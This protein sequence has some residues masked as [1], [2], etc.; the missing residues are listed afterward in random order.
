[1]DSTTL[2]IIIGASVGGLIIIG[3]ILYCI[4]RRKKTASAPEKKEEVIEVQ[5]VQPKTD[6]V[7]DEVKFSPLDATN[8]DPNSNLKE[9]QVNS[10]TDR[11]LLSTTVDQSYV[12]E[13]FREDKGSQKSEKSQHELKILKKL[14]ADYKEE[15][16]RMD[17][18]AD[19][20]KELLEQNKNKTI[21]GSSIRSKKIEEKTSK[22]IV[23]NDIRVFT[24]GH[25][26]NFYSEEGDDDEQEDVE[27]DFN[28]NIDYEKQLQ[29]EKNEVIRKLEE[30]KKQPVTQ[31]HSQPGKEMT[32]EEH[33][34]FMW[35][36]DNDQYDIKN[37]LK[38]AYESHTS[39]NYS[40]DLQDNKNQ[41][42]L[43]IK[44]DES[45]K[46]K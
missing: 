46:I 27:I 43:D 1:M 26:E 14:E 22:E 24:E 31:N 29:I 40:S 6:Q 2:Y 7:P 8:V 30:S 18:K 33:V 39:S 5:V 38:G 11:K 13:H 36:S 25:R 45:I 19:K 16:F 9:S 3:V 23:A 17:S 15:L 28:F 41:I 21:D 37:A 44:K 10:T 32:K 35:E 12:K 34:D 4:C 42:V 20:L